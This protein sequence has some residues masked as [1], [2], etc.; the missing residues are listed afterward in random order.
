MDGFFQAS[1]AVLIT[2][3]LSLT[4]GN[5]NRSF[6]ALLAMAVCAMIML[7]GLHYLEPVIEFIQELEAVGRLSEDMVKILLKT[8]F[9][10]ILTEITALLCADS[11]NISLAQALRLV[12]SVTILWLSLPVFRGLLNLVQRI[13]EGI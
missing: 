10:G 11:G 4:L 9:I 5:Q 12:G 1:G 2:V 13:L 7:L 3:I 8:A 6:A